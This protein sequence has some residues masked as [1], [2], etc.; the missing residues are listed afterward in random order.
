MKMNESTRAGVVRVDAAWLD[1]MAETVAL[2]LP[3]DDWGGA[4][5]EPKIAAALGK[6]SGGATFHKIQALV[7]DGTIRA[8]RY[9]PADGERLS[10]VYSAADVLSAAQRGLLV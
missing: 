3:P 9:R 8:G 5:T 4:V 6:N 7:A 1:A 2:H 10:M